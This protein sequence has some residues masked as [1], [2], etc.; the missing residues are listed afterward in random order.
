MATAR[1]RSA[2]AV[3]APR[4]QQFEKLRECAILATDGELGHVSDLYFD[5]QSWTARY[6]VIDTGGWLSGRLVLIPPHAI[7]QIDVVRQVVAVNLTRQQVQDSPAAETD[8]PVSRQDEMNLYDYYGFP[9]YWTGPYRW[10]LAPLGYGPGYPVGALPAGYE[11]RSTAA[12]EVAARERE[13]ADPHLRSA[14]DVRGHRIQ[15]TDGGLG[16]IEDFLVEEGSLAIRYLVVD[17]RSWWP[18][19]HVLVS[20]EWID[21][22]SWDAATVDVSLD[23]EAVRSAPEFDPVAPLERDYEMRYHRHLGRPGYWARPEE[24]WRR[25]WAR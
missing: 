19:K 21:A 22:V 24:E 7:G 9:Y 15:A 20:T 13:Q 4:L 14:A 2:G 18:G 8:R 3:A 25:P 5:D 11:P 10:G 1:E 6:L 23:K 12:E 16:H 17:P